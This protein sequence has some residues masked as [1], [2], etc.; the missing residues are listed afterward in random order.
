MAGSVKREEVR[1]KAEGN[2]E[3]ERERESRVSR[4]DQ[5]YAWINF[6]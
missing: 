5:S 4:R 3:R 2:R 6:A 1:G